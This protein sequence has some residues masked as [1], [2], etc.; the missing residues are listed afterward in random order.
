[1]ADGDNFDFPP[2]LIE[3]LA[4]QPLSYLLPVRDCKYMCNFKL[5]DPSGFCCSEY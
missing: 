1:M 2:D 4:G 5:V 3:A